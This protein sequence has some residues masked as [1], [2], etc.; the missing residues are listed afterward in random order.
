MTRTGRSGK[1]TTGNI[2]PCIM[3]GLIFCFRVGGQAIF[4][5]PE[6]RDGCHCRVVS[7]SDADGAGPLP[8]TFLRTLCMD[9]RVRPTYSKTM[10]AR[11]RP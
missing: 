6:G 9:R 5:K 8:L 4:L 2:N 3:H 11:I 1:L 7:R 10:G